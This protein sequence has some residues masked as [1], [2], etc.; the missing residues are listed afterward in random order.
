MPG[1]VTIFLGLAAALPGTSTVAGSIEAPA[2]R[3]PVDDDWWIGHTMVGGTLNPRAA[4]AFV[5][6]R[7]HWV[8]HHSDAKLFDGL[9]VDV[10]TEWVLSASIRPSLFV[11]WSPI[12]ILKLRLQYDLWGWLGAHTGLGHGL[13]FADENAPFDQESLRARKGEERPG[14]G[15]RV[16]LAP[17]LQMKVWRL[18]AFSTLELSAW[19]VHGDGGYWLEPIND[20]LISLGRIDYALKNTAF[21]LFQIWADDPAQI[22]I[23]L[24][25]EYVQTWYAGLSRHRLGGVLALTPYAELFGIDRPTVFVVAGVNLSDTN[26]EGGFYGALALRLE[27][28][29]LKDGP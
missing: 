7:R 18:I 14:M 6:L 15:H 10:G 28:D 27:L 21:F 1:L 2:Q 4:G 26:R 25:D 5:G 16:T 12:K 9:W 8:Y 3:G 23:G 17:T 29:L 11:E 20:N 22:C 24:Q 19:Y 13:I